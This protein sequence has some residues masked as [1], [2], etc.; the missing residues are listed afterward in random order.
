[1][2]D[3]WFVKFQGNPTTLRDL[4]KFRYVIHLLNNPD[5]EIDN[6]SL[7]NEFKMPEESKSEIEIQAEEPSMHIE[8]NYVD[9]HEEEEISRIK[10][11]V[12]QLLD[13]GRLSTDK[14]KTEIEKKL[15]KLRIVL[16]KLDILLIISQD[17]TK[18]KLISRTKKL[19]KKM[20]NARSNVRQNL[21]KAFEA[22]SIHLPTLTEYLVDTIKT[23]QSYA[24]FS[25]GNPESS[26]FIKW[27][28]E[29]L[30]LV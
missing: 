3:T 1:M 10:E 6:M 7:V 28:I 17:W 4:K 9:D 11:H 13:E 24:I 25:P 12:L 19:R 5:K 30:V 15:E 23:T 8:S 20:S 18:F 26:K 21:N 14:K 22:I 2:G 29:G 16:K 27:R